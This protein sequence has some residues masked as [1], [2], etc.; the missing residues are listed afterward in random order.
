[1]IFMCSAIT[2]EDFLRFFDDFG[3]EALWLVSAK[4]QTTSCEVWVD[5][6]YQA[7]RSLECVR[8]KQLTLRTLNGIPGCV[9]A[10][11]FPLSVL[12]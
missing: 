1:M 12:G 8:I 2:H 11:V 3:P 10:C 9:D 6:L 4:L 5:G 7:H